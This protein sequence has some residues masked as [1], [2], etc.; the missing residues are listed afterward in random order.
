MKAVEFVEFWAELKNGLIRIP[1]EII[2]DLGDKFRAKVMIETRE[3]KIIKGTGI[4][5]KRK[6][7]PF[8]KLKGFKFDRDEASER[9]SK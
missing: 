9:L 7:S 5:K 3:S 4:A 8:L 6:F 2:A 1:E